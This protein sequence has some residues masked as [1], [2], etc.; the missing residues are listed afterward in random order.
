MGKVMGTE[1]NNKNTKKMGRLNL[2]SDAP[3]YKH[4]YP[5]FRFMIA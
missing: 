5:P 2:H 1:Q 3:S 4:Y